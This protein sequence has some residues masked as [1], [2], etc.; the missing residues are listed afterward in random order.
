MSVIDKLTVKDLAVVESAEIQFGPGLNVVTGETGA[1]KS[2]LV[3]AINLLC[4]GRADHSVIRRGAEQSAVMAEISLQ[5]SVVANIAPILEDAGIDPCEDGILILRR[6]ISPNGSGRC[7][8][9][10]CPST[11]Q[12]MRRIGEMLV[13]MHGPH[14]NQSL[15]NP[16]FQ[17]EALD[18][19]GHCH[20]Q[21]GKFAAIWREKRDL[22][23]QREELAGE[24]DAAERELDL[25]KYQIREIAEAELS[26]DTDG[27]ALVSEHAEAANVGSLLELGNGVIQM[28][29]DAEGS[30]VEL[31]ADITR[32]L[33][34]MQRHGSAE[35]TEWISEARSASIQL[36]ELSQSISSSLSRIDASPERMQWLEDRMTLVQ[37]L[38]RKYGAT[39]GEILAFYEKSKVRATEL[40]SRGRIIG[41][42]DSQIAAAENRLAAEAKRLTEQRA[43]ASGK[44]AKAVSRQLADLG[45]PNAALDIAVSPAKTDSETGRDSVEFGFAPN[46]GESMLPLRS[47]ASSGEISRV[48]LALKTVLA[49]HDK[50]PVLVF[51]EI[52]AN[53]GG[54]IANNVGAK[55]SEA[56]G[57]HQI[58]CITHLPQVAAWGLSHFVVT[59]QVEGGRTQTRIRSVAETDRI[60]EIAR[61][62]GGADLTSVTVE[63]AR[64]LLKHAVQR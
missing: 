26:P 19:F 64:E 24:G 39:V 41:E 54:E 6:T 4:G 37:K 61:M 48:M 7:L 43:A 11:V 58:I 47:I 23:R 45:L 52:D 20:E 59:K 27:D 63:H 25:L 13:D 1:G 50:I 60:D 3:G 36:N 49:E 57:S 12:T 62:L 16:L 55:L 46:P 8:V 33:D 30:V 56:S 5:E 22:V 17:L 32:H 9:N 28:L 35:A 29:T 51:D 2:V 42:L 53:I 44:L 10:N 31:L 18:S 15:F 14:D 40:E 34:E 21:R 38:K